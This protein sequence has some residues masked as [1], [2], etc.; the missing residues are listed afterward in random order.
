MQRHFKYLEGTFLKKFEN[1]KMRYLSC[2]VVGILHKA[3]QITA[4]LYTQDI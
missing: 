3:Q 2:E 1:Q 4:S